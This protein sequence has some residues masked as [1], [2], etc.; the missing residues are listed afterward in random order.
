VSNDS[1]APAVYFYHHDQLGSVRALTNSSGVVQNT[2]DYDAYGKVTS[3]T[4]SVYN[5][6]GY[7]GEYT[8]FGATVE[9]LQAAFLY[10]GKFP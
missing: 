7:A 3:S 9:E 6:F 8:D 10:K 5:P 1:D 2:Y 4:G